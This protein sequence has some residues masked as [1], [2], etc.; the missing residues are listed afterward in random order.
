[1]LAVLAGLHPAKF[2]TAS[3]SQTTQMTI[4]KFAALVA[5][6]AGL[7]SVGA[8]A[9]IIPPGGR[10]TLT[11]NTP[12]MSNDVVNATTVYYTNY[13]GDSLPVVGGGGASN[14]TITAQISLA[15]NSS[16]ELA[17][18][19]HDIFV[20][21]TG[22]WNICAG[23]AWANISSSP[24][25]GS[26]AGTTQLTQQ[27][28]GL[29]VNTNLVSNCYN[30][31]SDDSF[32]AGYGLYVGSVYMTG[33]GETSMQFKPTPAS[34][35]TNNM[36]G[37]YNAY[38]RV[39]TIARNNDSASPAWT[40]SSPAWE[41]LDNNVNNNIGFIDGLAQSSVDAQVQINMY[42]SSSSVVGFVAVDFDSFTAAPSG[43]IGLTSSTDTP[44]GVTVTAFDHLQPQLG[45]HYAAAVQYA[46]GPT[47]TFFNASGGTEELKLELEM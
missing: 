13:N 47:V 6:T 42:T 16:W 43:V 3:I 24:W 12:V 21:Y 44:Y 4:S 35:G 37:L 30:G 28:D 39:R 40:Y 9:Q 22:S 18:S 46:S 1:M 38:N 20:F 5:I 33:N 14:Q 19:I 29:W 27:P 26:G 11:S 34:G 10:L 23:P 25:R 15:L 7:F 2:Q 45:F 8:V 32:A 17:G 31:T 41:V 36:L